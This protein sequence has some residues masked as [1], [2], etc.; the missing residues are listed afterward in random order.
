[1]IDH[2]IT[3]IV[4]ELGLK[5]KPKDAIERDILLQRHYGITHDSLLRRLRKEKSKY[6][7][8]AHER[9]RNNLINRL[10][11][12]LTPLTYAHFDREKGH[13]GDI[14]KHVGQHGNI[15]ETIDEGEAASL[16]TNYRVLGHVP[17][18]EVDDGMLTGQGKKKKAELKGKYKKAA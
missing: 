5:E 4:K 1:M 15:R 6:R 14:I 7:L 13:I 18:T 3:S 17:L 12:E 8:E 10:A 9:E 11:Q 2:Y 16:L